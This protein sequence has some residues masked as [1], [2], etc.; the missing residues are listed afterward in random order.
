ML[1]N[2]LRSEQAI[3]MSIHI[4]RVFTRKRE[5]LLSH[6][7]VFQKLEQLEGRITGHDQEIQVIFDHLTELVPPTE[8]R[9]EPIGFE[10]S[11]A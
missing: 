1:A 4:I 9:R 3:A 8:H 7:V 11:E 5:V 6:Q 10:P 2:V